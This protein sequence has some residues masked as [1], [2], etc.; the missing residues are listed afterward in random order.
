MQ[1]DTGPRSLAEKFFRTCLY[2]CGGV[3]VLV[4]AIELLKTIWWILLIAAVVI[5]LVSILVRW[6]RRR[7]NWL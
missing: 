6:W 4:L 3:I 2:L 1:G 7:N 5:L